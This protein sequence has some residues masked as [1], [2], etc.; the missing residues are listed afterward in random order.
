MG[1]YNTNMSANDTRTNGSPDKNLTVGRAAVVL[2][3]QWGDEGKG[4]LVDLLAID[5]DLVC[6]CQGGN[7]AGHTV[8]ANGVKY[9]FHLLPSGVV[10]DKTISVIGNGVV[11]HLPGLFDEI[12]A[13][14]KKGMKDID[15]RLIISNRAHI[16]L[17][18][19]QAVDG[20]Q[21]EGRGS[22]LIGTTKKGIGPTYSSKAG[23]HGLRAC[24]LISDFSAFEEKYLSLVNQFRTL[25]PEVEH[26]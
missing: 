7:N 13:A 8:V 26:D 18:I 3:A 6:R 12:E 24:D 14:E 19:H 5:A 23:R 10:N 22:K 15:N 4:K 2:G 16:V 1:L 20:L 11:V 21:E 25:H 17:D 9:D